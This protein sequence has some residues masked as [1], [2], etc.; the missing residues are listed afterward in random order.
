MALGS[1]PARAQIA[2][3]GGEAELEIPAEPSREAA[4]GE[5]PASPAAT[6]TAPST[7]PSPPPAPVPTPPPSESGAATPSTETA[8]S[9]ALERRLGELERR[10]QAVEGALA[11]QEAATRGEPP[12]LV[13][14]PEI[15]P[16]SR[17]VRTGF[18]LSAY[19]QAD[20]LHS[21]ISE[22]QLQ[23]GGA[24]LNQD[25]LYLRRARLRFDRG[26][27]Y[28]AFSLELDANTVS[29][30][31]VGIRRA[32]ASV[33]YQ[34]PNART[35]PPIVMVTAG[36][37]DLPF[38]YELYESERSSMF[39]ERSLVSSA[40][41]PTKQDAAIKISGAISFVR[42]GLSLSNGEPVDTRGFPRD[43]NAAKD[44]TGRVGVEVPVGS[45][46]RVVGGTSFAQGRGFH[47]G[48][49]EVKSG[50]AWNDTNGNGQ[51]D[52]GEVV[53][54][55]GVVASPSQN[56]DRWAYGLDLGVYVRTPIGETHVYGELIAASNYD[57]GFRPSDPFGA[58]HI[59][60]RQF[61]GYAAVTQ[62]VTRYGF[63]GFRYSTY[64]P[65]S[66]VLEQRQGLAL[67]K[68]QTV[69]TLSPMVGLRLPKRARLFFQYDFTSDYIARDATGVPSD[70]KNDAWTVRL[71]ADL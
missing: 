35:L 23:Q 66:D 30:P 5:G 53:A 28:A 13:R 67:P 68:T 25:R 9:A 61:G 33:Y 7:W 46:V 40:L 24:P 4:P 20:Y 47:A 71:Q 32:E 59:D 50:L 51:I 42:Y 56:F 55:P 19:L 29:T 17:P 21:Q 45:A 27:D 18:L 6:S 22:D 12:W 54:V 44:L 60:T 48:T 16:F 11:K 1:I 63:A 31:V 39:M 58:E 62:E 3:Q 57:R 49:S 38:G 26:W 34:G 10:N 70:A 64:D 43:P 69:Q 41:W 2:P 37:T 65:N 14:D 52:A 8:K 36:I 15:T